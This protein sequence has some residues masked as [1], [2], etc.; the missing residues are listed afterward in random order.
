MEPAAVALLIAFPLVGALSRRWYAV[1]LPLVG[2]PVF[3]IGL[4]QNWW[5]D[6]LGDAWRYPA[7]ALTAFGVVTTSLAVAAAR[8]FG[9]A[10][11]AKPPS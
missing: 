10:R 6:G 5:G 4:H 11:F 9:I 1:A 2:W 7:T 8:Q 3:F